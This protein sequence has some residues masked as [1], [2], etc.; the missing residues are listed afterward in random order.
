MLLPPLYSSENEEKKYSCE[1][2]DPSRACIPQSKKR[3]GAEKDRGDN[4]TIINLHL[5]CGQQLPGKYHSQL[6]SPQ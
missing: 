2:I 1:N 3:I 4:L 5:Q 6:S